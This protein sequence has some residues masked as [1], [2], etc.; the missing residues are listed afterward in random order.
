[1]EE[2]VMLFLVLDVDHLIAVLALADVTAAVGFVE[3]DA[4]SRE[5]LVA[6][7]ALL[8]LAFHR[9]VIFKFNISPTT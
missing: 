3:V 7:A 2:Y 9:T 4:V 6:V 8:G 5:H 1:L